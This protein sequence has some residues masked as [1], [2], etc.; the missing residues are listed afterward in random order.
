MLMTVP[1]GIFLILALTI[2]LVVARR[3]DSKRKAQLV[4][5]VS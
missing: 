5:G 2:S 4:E 3:L 1:V